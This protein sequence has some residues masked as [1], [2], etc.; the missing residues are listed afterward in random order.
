M[1]DPHSS[2]SMRSD[3]KTLV[4]TNRILMVLLSV[5]AVQV[6]L[7]GDKIMVMG[8]NVENFFYSTDRTLTAEGNPNTLVYY[9]DEEGR[10]PIANGIYDL[11]GRR[12]DGSKFKIQGSGLKPDLYIVNG[13]KVVIK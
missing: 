2:A 10:Q 11:Q 9:T 13:K 7:A 3:Y 5:M 4:K 12:V 8:H 1:S 6:A